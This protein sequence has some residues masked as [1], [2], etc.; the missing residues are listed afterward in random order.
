MKHAVLEIVV[1]PSLVLDTGVIIVLTFS[2]QDTVF[3]PTRHNAISISYFD[4]L[5]ALEKQALFLKLIAINFEYVHYMVIDVGGLHL[6]NGWSCVGWGYLLLLL[7]HWSCYWLVLSL[8][9]ELHDDLVSAIGVG[10]FVD[11]RLKV[12]LGADDNFLALVHLGDLEAV[13]RQG[14]PLP[15]LFLKALEISR[16]NLGHLVA[17]GH[18]E[19]IVFLS[20][21][22]GG[23]GRHSWKGVLVGRYFLH[24]CRNSSTIVDAKPD[25]CFVVARPAG[26]I[27]QTS[28]CIV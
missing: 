6:R 22:L 23:R 24:S 20:C 19:L 15:G 21:C 18:L 3:Q 28:L 26:K 27:R 13:F 14:Q 7:L 9:Q 8:S 2:D 17:V 4:S 5:R 16:S 25:Q 10:W 12:V 11:H 1:E